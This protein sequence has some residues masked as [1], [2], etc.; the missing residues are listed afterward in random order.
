MF[1]I[2]LKCIITGRGLVPVIRQTSKGNV[3]LVGTD[4]KWYSKPLIQE[5]FY[6]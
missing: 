4:R 3:Y 5:A 1:N 6:K 2:N